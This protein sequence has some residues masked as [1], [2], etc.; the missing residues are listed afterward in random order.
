MNREQYWGSDVLNGAGV[1][2]LYD[3]GLVEL[4]ILAGEL[5]IPTGRW[6]SVVYSTELDGEVMGREEAI[7]RYPEYFV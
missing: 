7:E 4:A 1:Y 3:K 6:S 2:L 5:V